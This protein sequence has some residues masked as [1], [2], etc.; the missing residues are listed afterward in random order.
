MKPRSLSLLPFVLRRAR[1]KGVALIITLG[2]LALLLI[3]AMSFAFEAQTTSLAARNLN[4]VSRSRLLARG[5][6]ERALGFLANELGTAANQ[7]TTWMNPGA[8]FYYPS[9]SADAW[10]GRGY[11]PFVTTTASALAVEMNDTNSAMNVLFTTN[12]GSDTASFTPATALVLPGTVSVAWYSDTVF[13]TDIAGGNSGTAQKIIGRVFYNIIDETGKVDPSVVVADTSTDQGV[14]ASSRSGAALTELRL[15]DFFNTDA[16]NHTGAAQNLAT[17]LM[18]TNATAAPPAGVTHNLPA[19]SRWLSYSNLFAGAATSQ[20]EADSITL[21]LFPY[22][23]VDPEQYW[24]DVNA[25]S[26]VATT[27]LH[28]RIDLSAITSSSASVQSVYDALIGYDATLNA[29]RS[30]TTYW[31]PWLK[32]VSPTDVATARKWAAQLALDIGDFSATTTPT[33]FNRVLIDSTTGALTYQT[34]STANPGGS[35]AAVIYGHANMPY[36]TEMDVILNT[37]VSGGTY[38][39]RPSFKFQFFWPNYSGATPSFRAVVNYSAKIS[40][41]PAA[42]TGTDNF[43]AT[44]SPLTLT[45]TIASGGGTIYRSNAYERQTGSSLGFGSPLND[46]A[47]TGYWIQNFSINTLDLYYSTNGGTTWRRI[48]HYPVNDTGAVR[49]SWLQWGENDNPITVPPHAKA[50]WTAGTDAY[51]L[52]LRFVTDPLMADR[53]GDD[54][55]FTSVWATTPTAATGGSI[56]PSVATYFP[57]SDTGNVADTTGISTY[58]TNRYSGITLPPGTAFTH[59]GQLGRMHSPHTANTSLRLWSLSSSDS[60]LYDGYILDM[61]KIGSASV[62]GRINPNGKQ[63]NVIRGLFTGVIPGTG[64]DAAN[65]T[66]IATALKAQNAKPLV[67]RGELG[68]CFA[69]ASFTNSGTAITQASDATVESWLQAVIELTDV[70]YNFYTVLVTAQSLTD[71]GA[72]QTNDAI[73][74]STSGGNHYARP[75]SRARLQAYVMRDAYTNKLTIIRVEPL[76]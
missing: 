39:L 44:I 62:R 24:T 65:L 52:K 15:Y 34:G 76:D 4:D 69:N 68:K 1:P 7:P 5:G 54:T 74:W 48:R 23:A 66:S 3:L 2:I 25:D 70:R 27:E 20:A 30:D 60:E 17:R 8:Q 73:L 18:A 50:G 32:N 26:V 33:D 49:S 63:A 57:T 21:S 53:D 11:L 31:S 29:N 56:V 67:W 55:D 72:T 35:T 19:N 13:A 10:Y 64:A 12:N 51:Y 6:L 22:S 58:N 37:R 14:T 43:T 45:S 36:L 16:T 28:N 46:V 75:M 61:F 40:C 47:T 38:Q 42:S 71:I 59:I 41:D 9:N